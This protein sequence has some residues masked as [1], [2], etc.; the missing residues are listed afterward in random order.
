MTGE[1]EVFETGGRSYLLPSD[2][3]IW[4]CWRCQS[5]CVRDKLAAP[6]WCNRALQTILGLEE[7]GQYEGHG[8]PVC[9]RCYKMASRGMR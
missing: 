1:C 3:K 2:L 4:I 9:Q 8:R 5:P 6:D 7:N